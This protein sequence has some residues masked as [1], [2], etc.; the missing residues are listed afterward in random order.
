MIRRLWSWWVEVLSRQ[1]SGECLAMMRIIVAI[2]VLLMIGAV[3]VPDL[4]GVIYYGPEHGGSL[5]YNKNSWRLEA[6]GGP[7]PRVVWGLIVTTVFSAL[8]LALGLGGR[9]AALVAGQCLLALRDINSIQGSY[10]A[11][12]SNALWLCVLARCDTTWSLSCRLRTG[13][14]TSEDKVPAWPRLLGVVQLVIVYTWTGL[15][16]VSA[17]WVGDFSAIFYILQDPNWQRVDMRWAA[18]VYPLTRLATAVVWVWEAS[19]GMILIA[20]Y[21]RET[22]DRPGRLR[23]LFNRYDLRIG[24]MF[25]GIG[26][27]ASIAALMIVGPFFLATLAF[28]PC[29]FTPREWRAGWERALAWKQ[30][31]RPDAGPTG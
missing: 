1:E 27:H 5:Q 26:A 10:G 6:L 30:R 4:V 2:T 3:I 28:Y 16:K 25:V 8:A 12:V 7:S 17:Y 19:F 23:A 9:V 20:A 13:S 21:F 29:L 22:K 11:L 18:H 14:W 24:Y 31:R 15:S